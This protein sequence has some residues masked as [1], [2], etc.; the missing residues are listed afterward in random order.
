M[1]A[2]SDDIA[3]QSPGADM[4]AP[5]RN[6]LDRQAEKQEDRPD[7]TRLALSAVRALP[8]DGAGDGRAAE[9][10]RQRR[11][12][13]PS[14]RPRRRRPCGHRPCP[15][16]RSKSDRP[17]RESEPPRANEI[18]MSTNGMT[19]E[20]EFILR[21]LGEAFPFRVAALR[22]VPRQHLLA[23]DR[24]GA[25]PPRARLGR[26]HAVRQARRAGVFHLRDRPGG[27]SGGAVHHPARSASSWPAPWTAKSS[28]CSCPRRPPCC[29]SP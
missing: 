17:R 27:H 18:P 4:H 14:R 16:R 29:A 2:S 21:R 10:P 6:R 15:A 20:S 23:R 24:G 1:R 3:L 25:R 28:G 9:L 11:S 13:R 7:G 22:L 26:A 19:Q 8:A 5:R 12:D